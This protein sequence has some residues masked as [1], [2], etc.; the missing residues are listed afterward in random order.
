MDLQHI[1]N[2][3]NLQDLVEQTEQLTGNQRYKRGIAHDSLVVDTAKQCWW[4]NSKSQRGDLIDWIGMYTLGFDGSWNPND[5]TMFKLALEKIGELTGTPIR[6]K[7]QTPE[8]KKQA[9]LEKSLMGIALEH[10]IYNFNHTPDAI[11]YMNS[12]ALT[13]ETCQQYKIG[14]SNGKLNKKIKPEHYETAKK[15]GLLEYTDDNGGVWFDVIPNGFIV[16]SHYKHAKIRYFSGRSITKKRHANLKSEKEPLLYLNN[17]W[18]ELIIVEGQADALSLAQLGFN[19]LALCGTN[20]ANVDTDMLKLFKSIYLALDND[21]AGLK[22][23]YSL[24]KQIGPLIKLI[25]L[26]EVYTLD[27]KL[28]SDVNDMLKAGINPTDVRLWIANSKTY[29]NTMINNIALAPKDDRDSQLEELFI[30]ITQLEGFTLARYR[31]R[32]C[33]RLKISRHDFDKLLSI[34]KNKVEP[35]ETFLKGQQYQIKDGWMVIQ[36]MGGG[37]IPLCN[38]EFKITGLICHDNGSGDLYQEYTMQAQDSFS[39]PLA[40]TNIPTEDFEKMSWINKHYP[41]VIVEAGRSSKDQLRAAIQHRSGKYQRHFIYEHTGWRKIQGHQTYLTTSGAIGLPKDFDDTVAVDL[42]AGRPQTNLNRYSLPLYPENI[43]EACLYSLAYWDIMNPIAT[44][45]MWAAMFLAPLNPILP[46]NFGLWM[47][48][49]SGS[50]KSVMAVLALAHFGKWHGRGA[51][52][53]AP[54]NFISTANNILMDSFLCKDIPLLIDDFAPGNSIREMRERDE[55]ASKLL[56]SVGNKAGRGRMRDGKRYQASYPPRCLAIITAEDI[57]SGQSILARGI[58]VRV[59]TAPAGTD[60]RKEIMK[61]ITLAQNEHSIHYKHAMSGYIM[62]LIKNWDEL[63]KRLPT[64]VAKNSKNITAVGHARLADAFGKLITAVETALLFF[65]E[66][67]AISEDQATELTAR[68]Y[69]NLQSIM[70]EHSGQ[71]EDLDPI[72]IFAETLRENLDSYD[73]YLLPASATEVS[74]HTTEPHDAGLDAD[75]NYIKLLPKNA[76]L[77]GWYDAHRIFLLPK[78]VKLIMTAYASGGVPFPIGRNSLYN[79]LQEKGWLQMGTSKSTQTIYIERE[80]TSPRVLVLYKKAVYPD[81]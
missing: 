62:W 4:W 65:Q 8:Q 55:V 18:D 71:I 5:P 56:R 70:V 43:K 50:F 79:R 7:P 74:P 77:V 11:E 59:V 51:D 57:P 52:R 46:T 13:L 23:I 14:Y 68:A 47:H 63:E 76:K 40:T 75:G 39:N 32:I 1:K 29:L 44:I 60:E 3:I 16:Y 27:K 26:P 25:I 66:V 31:T 67:G 15:L 36:K 72:L 20:I 64:Q 10:Y 54:A 81:D 19:V 45:P 33:D 41:T 17:G 35:E 30:T 37:Y 49:K 21:N 38:A 48:G 34:A 58:G 78:A 73:W 9:D 28:C 80:K 2:L 12:R 42:R 61:K 53:H 69:S 24:A 22:N 6:F